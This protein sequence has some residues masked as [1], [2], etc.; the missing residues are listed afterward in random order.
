LHITAPSQ[1]A[2][3]VD[4]GATVGG[5]TTVDIHEEHEHRAFVHPGFYFGVLAKTLAML[6]IGFVLVTLFPSLRPTAPGSSKE[7]LRDMG[8]GFVALIATPVAAL[9]I[10]FTII[11]IPTSIVLGMVYALLLFLSALVVAYFAGARLSFGGEGGKGVVLRTGLALLAIL[12]VVEI[13][14]IGGGLHFLVLIFGMGVLVLHLRE[15]Y[16]NRRGPS[17]AS[18]VEADEVRG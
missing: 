2:L 3:E 8:I 10:A 15:L 11:G 17:D 6:L 12:F 14:F 7:V 4:D 13:P 9:I 16:L 5:E 1:E 18:M